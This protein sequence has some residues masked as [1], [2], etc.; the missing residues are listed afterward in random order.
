MGPDLARRAAR[1][2]LPLGLRIALRRAPPTLAYLLSRRPRRS[3]GLEGFDHLQCR[4]TSPLRRPGSPYPAE[5][6]RGKERNVALAAARLDGVVIGPGE[7]FSW[8]R[9][10]GPPLRLLGWVP[11]PEVRGDGIAGGLGGGAC[12]VANMVLWL[13]LQSGLEIV[14]RHRHDVDL[15]PDH[16]RTAPFGSGATVFYPTRDLRLRNPGPAP[17]RLG[18]RVDDGALHG[19]ARF[20]VDP[21]LRWELVELDHRFVRSGGATWREN[22]L[23]RR[24]LRDGE[25]VAEALVAENRARTLYEVADAE[26]TGGVGAGHPPAGRAGATAAR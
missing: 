17:L 19:E 15:F 23:V 25:V 8:T 4:R 22:R 5:L 20:P 13:A 24:T 7:V 12:Q 18:L 11:G 6:Q 16:E 26:V 14:E 2:L 21:G 3:R 10:V 1:A 9:E